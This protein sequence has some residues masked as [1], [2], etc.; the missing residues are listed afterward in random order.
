MRRTAP[1]RVR[2]SPS[3]RVGSR[4]TSHPPPA[5]TMI[6][7]PREIASAASSVCLFALSF[8]HHHAALYGSRPGCVASSI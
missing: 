5:A 3:C 7:A 2:R 6:R 8:D 4:C 1:R